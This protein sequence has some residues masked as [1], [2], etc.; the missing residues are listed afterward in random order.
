M[1]REERERR[2][3]RGLKVYF[4]LATWHAG[5]DGVNSADVSLRRV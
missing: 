4:F 1:S 5:K 2:E 3:E